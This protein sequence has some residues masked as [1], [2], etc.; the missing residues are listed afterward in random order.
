M[1]VTSSGLRG[2]SIQSLKSPEGEVLPSRIE[3]GSG[4]QCI[5][6]IR[7]R[8]KFF[9]VPDVVRC[10]V[11]VAGSATRLMTSALADGRTVY[12]VSAAAVP[13]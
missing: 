11:G 8:H 6:D 7:R 1:A 12:L 2:V 10:P 13:R 9:L 4:G 3:V 5:Y